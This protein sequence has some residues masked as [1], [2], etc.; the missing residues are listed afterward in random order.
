MDDRHAAIS[1][2]TRTH[3]HRSLGSLAPR[4]TQAGLWDIPRPDLALPEPSQSLRGLPTR[5]RS[6]RLKSARA[7]DAHD[8]AARLSQSLRT[9]P[10]ALD[11]RPAHPGT[12]RRQP[13]RSAWPCGCLERPLGRAQPAWH[14]CQ[15]RHRRNRSNRAAT[16]TTANAT[17]T[18]QTRSGPIKRE[19]GSRLSGQGGNASEIKFQIG[20]VEAPEGVWAQ[21]TG[22]VAH[23][24]LEPV[25]GQRRGRR[26]CR[27]RRQRG[28]RV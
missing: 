25:E 22:R 9:P 21:Q 5:L 13:Q 10:R 8:A 6:P 14:P 19:A 7:C 2:R 27:W 28:R 16:L 17:R 1:A 26:R 20:F 4:P 23:L 12:R 11:A 15:Q 3:K 24:A 18:G